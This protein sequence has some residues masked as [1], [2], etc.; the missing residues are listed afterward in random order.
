MRLLKRIRNTS[1]DL[2]TRWVAITLLC[3]LVVV[4]A[5]STGDAQAILIAGGIWVVAGVVT[6]A[7]APLG[8]SEE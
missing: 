2:K 1:P 6:L 7:T 3:A 8:P 5:A 4:P